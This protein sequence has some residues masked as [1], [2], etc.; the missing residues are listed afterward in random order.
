MRS[1]I[2]ALHYKETPFSR[3]QIYAVNLID[4]VFGV[5]LHMYSA[6]LIA[7]IGIGKSGK[8]KLG[9][10]SVLAAVSRE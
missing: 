4:F 1:L 2:V 3:G 10:D 7:C 6:S 5:V 9:R 8:F